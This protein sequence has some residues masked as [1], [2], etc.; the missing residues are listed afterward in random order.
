MLE[1]KWFGHVIFHFWHEC[2]GEL[3]IQREASY[4]RFV[5]WLDMF[6]EFFHPHPKHREQI[7]PDS[8]ACAIS[9]SVF[10]HHRI[11]E[12]CMA[13]SK[14]LIVP[15]LV[16]KFTAVASSPR[17]TVSDFSPVMRF[18][19]MTIFSLYL[20]HH[21]H[22]RWVSLSSKSFIFHLRNQSIH[23]YRS[24]FFTFLIDA[25]SEILS[26][27]WYLC[28]FTGRALRCRRCIF[29]FFWLSPWG[30]R[31]ALYL[32]HFW[33]YDGDR[34]HHWLEMRAP[35]SLVLTPPRCVVWIALFDHSH[36]GMRLQSLSWNSVIRG[37]GCMTG[38]PN[39]CSSWIHR[40]G[41]G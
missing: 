12:S 15:L 24:G 9:D 14:R 36:P 18:P 37:V 27:Y 21:T 11:L 26:L 38:E 34:V 13:F 35:I 22:Y 3:A 33:R 23:D 29:H 10:T 17:L 32:R 25:S 16:P 41:Y 1:Q 19:S 8:T 5:G 4:S 30:R 2:I 40:C 28:V 39:H 31:T 6:F 7:F 20:E